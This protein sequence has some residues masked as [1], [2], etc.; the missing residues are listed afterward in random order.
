MQRDD[1]V[2]GY[3]E[4]LRKIVVILLKLSTVPIDGLTD[5]SKSWTD[6]SGFENVDFENYVA[7][8]YHYGKE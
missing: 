8:E 3:L 2:A 4:T 6:L 7:R 5:V 1:L